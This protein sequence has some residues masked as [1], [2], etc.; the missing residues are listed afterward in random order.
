MPE[1]TVLPCGVYGTNE[2]RVQ[3]D[4]TDDATYEGDG[5]TWLFA[6]RVTHSSQTVMLR[7]NNA[8]IGSGDNDQET[9]GELVTRVS[10]SERAKFVTLASGKH[11]AMA[12]SGTTAR[13]LM[14]KIGHN[15]WLSNTP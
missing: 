5:E 11:Y 1:A 13:G 9:A 3:S 7:E 8:A 4:D 12:S 6:M 2:V 10:N 14:V 15:P